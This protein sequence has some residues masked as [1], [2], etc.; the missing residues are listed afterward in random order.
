MIRGSSNLLR[1]RGTATDTSN[2]ELIAAQGAAVKI[3]VTDVTVSNSSSTDTEVHL[4]DGTTTIWT[5]PAPGTSGATHRFE[6][7]LALTLN[8]ALNFASAASVTTMTV[9]AAGYKGE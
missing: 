5:F 2:T 6:T 9:S 8:A 7:P 1:G 3:H 4:K